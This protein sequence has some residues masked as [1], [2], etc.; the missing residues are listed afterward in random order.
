MARCRSF[1][2][3]FAEVARRDLEGI[4]EFIA[5]DDPVAAA[6]ALE[7]IESRAASLKQF[8]ERGRV[9]PELAAFNIQLYRELIISPWR[10]IYRIGRKT[11]YVLAV[12]DG[13]RNVE[14]VLLSRL[15]RS[16]TG[17]RE[18]D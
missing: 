11:V 12:L 1:A 17:G 13:R 2:V 7:Q 14:D 18:S 8:P 6:H 5:M 16:Q 9:V 10:V 15:V 4:I 3:E